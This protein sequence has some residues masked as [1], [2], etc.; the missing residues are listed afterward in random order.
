MSANILK[1]RDLVLSLLDLIFKRIKYKLKSLTKIILLNSVFKL[2]YN[3]LY[4]F[5]ILSTIAMKISKLLQYAY[6]MLIIKI[7]IEI[8]FANM[9]I[10]HTNIYSRLVQVFVFS[11]F[12]YTSWILHVII[13]LWF[14]IPTETLT[15][16]NTRSTSARWI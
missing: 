6:K 14:M 7:V 8:Y 10:I 2:L 4:Y 1:V 9:P 15:W 16:L 13:T 5:Y 3:R 11:S 12:F